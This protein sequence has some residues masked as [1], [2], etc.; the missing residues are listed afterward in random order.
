MG[1]ENKS[2]PTSKSNWFKVSPFNVLL[3]IYGIRPVYDRPQK[4]GSTL[5]YIGIL[6]GIGHT[7]LGGH[8]FNLRFH[9]LLFLSF[10]FNRIIFGTF[11]LQLLVNFL[12]PLVLNFC[13]VKQRPSMTIFLN[14]IEDFDENMGQN[15]VDMT[16]TRKSDKKN[17]KLSYFFFLISFCFNLGMSLWHLFTMLGSDEYQVLGGIYYGIVILINIKTLRYLYKISQRFDLFKDLLNNIRFNSTN[18]QLN[19]LPKYPVKYLVK[20]ICK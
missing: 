2:P 10:L 16:A 20:R 11:F 3:T 1:K 5:S 7:I 12:V 13:L 8:M 6:F 19:G 15:H 17:I 14:K 4:D 9:R 18:R